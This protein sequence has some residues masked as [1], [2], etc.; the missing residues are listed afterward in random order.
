MLG[1]KYSHI[2]ISLQLFF[3]FLASSCNWRVPDKETFTRYEVEPNQHYPKKGN[4]I[5]V[6]YKDCLSF[7][8]TFYEAE[9]YH[10]DTTYQDSYNK[11]FGFAEGH[12]STI[13]DCFSNPNN[14]QAAMLGWRWYNELDTTYSIELAAYTHYG[15]ANDTPYY[16]VPLVSIQLYETVKV[17]ICALE[18]QYY[19]EIRDI[20]NNVLATYRANRIKSKTHNAKTLLGF[21]FG[22]LY[23][24]PSDKSMLVYCAYDFF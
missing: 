16:A 22:G 1:Y 3:I 20:D 23:P 2:L 8:L 7:T 19:F 17:D 5:D 15:C 13:L 18:K 21:Y 12:A 11:A 9:Y 24:N 14:G 6:F 4:P 10:K